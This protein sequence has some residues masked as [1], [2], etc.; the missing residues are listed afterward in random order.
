MMHNEDTSQS[1]DQRTIQFE[2]ILS[3]IN[4]LHALIDIEKETSA[5]DDQK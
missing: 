2:E 5:L 4:Q 1:K 3:E